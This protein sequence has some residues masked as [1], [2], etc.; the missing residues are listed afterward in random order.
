MS[1]GAAKAELNEHPDWKTR[2][3]SP[4]DKD[5]LFEVLDLPTGKVLGGFVLSTGEG[6]FSIE[7]ANAAGDWLVLHDNH[8][9]VLVFSLESGKEKGRAFGNPLAMSDA[10]S[11][12]CL[13]NVPGELEI[14]DMETMSKL[15]ELAFAHSV[16]S[17][18]FVGDGK[19][20]FV[21]TSDQC[22]YLIEPQ[23]SSKASDVH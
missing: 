6:S 13:Q 20:L 8:D 9:R 17:V 21:L 14:Y 16:S 7:K 15:D 18:D 3:P 11:M 5:L 12:L 19:N 23:K 2:F 1:E 10:S 4:K 22:A